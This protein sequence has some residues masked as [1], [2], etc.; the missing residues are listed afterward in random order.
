MLGWLSIFTLILLWLY[1]L[2]FWVRT[3]CWGKVKCRSKTEID[4]RFTEFRADNWDPLWQEPKCIYLCRDIM[5]FV[6][7]AS[8]FQCSR[9]VCKSPNLGVSSVMSSKQVGLLSSKFHISIRILIS[10][11]P[12]ITLFT[13]LSLFAYILL[14]KI[15]FCT[16]FFL[17][18]VIHV[19]N[20]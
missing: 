5:T 15:H 17:V 16:P 4:L 20:F 14:S 2:R 13:S 8:A 9:S 11:P 12:P 3:N 6:A 18:R 10:V 1:F 7:F 19:N